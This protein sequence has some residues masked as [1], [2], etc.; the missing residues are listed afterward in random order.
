M[1]KIIINGKAFF[2][3]LI[4]LMCLGNVSCSNAP[5][6]VVIP[7]ENLK[8]VICEELNLPTENITEAD[9]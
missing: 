9:M 1:P 8:K 6:I 5:G 2:L 7:D 4:L 3:V